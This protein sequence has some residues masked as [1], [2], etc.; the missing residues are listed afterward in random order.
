MNNSNTILSKHIWSKDE[1]TLVTRAYLEGKT[2]E[3][4]HFLVP[5]IKLTSLKILRIMKTDYVN[6]DM[7]ISFVID[8]EEYYGQVTN[9]LSHNPIV[10]SEVFKDFDLVQ[11]KEWI[12]RT[13]GLITKYI[14]Q[15]LLPEEGKW[16]LINDY[17]ICYSVDTGKMAK[18]L[19]G[20]EIDLIRAYDNKIIIKFNDDFY[21]LNNDNFIYFN[22]WFEKIPKEL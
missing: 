16:K 7:Y 14:K 5:N 11:T 22:Y 17:V 6:Y 12:I 10:K 2:V 21:S 4:A 9:I 15:W 1:T 18:I 13:K 19:K 20:S 3:E 8:G